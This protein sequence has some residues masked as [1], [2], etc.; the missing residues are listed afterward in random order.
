MLGAKRAGIADADKID[1][2]QMAGDTLWVS[3]TTPGFRAA[4]DVAQAAAPMHETVQQAQAFNQQR[5]QHLA[6]E[7][8]QRLQDAP[9][10]RGAPAIG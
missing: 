5:A 3:G 1:R 2:V 9:G 4:T 6:M 8:Q 10:G 7:A